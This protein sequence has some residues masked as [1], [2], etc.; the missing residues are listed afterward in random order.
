MVLSL[1]E[2]ILEQNQLF[3]LAQG[4]RSSEVYPVLSW[5]Y[6]LQARDKENIKSEQHG[7]EICSVHCIREAERKRE[8]SGQGISY[9]G[10][11]LVPISF[12]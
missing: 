6:C 1:N 3:I 12:N 10:L 8:E 9:K 7:E 11:S 5:P 4:F 2:K